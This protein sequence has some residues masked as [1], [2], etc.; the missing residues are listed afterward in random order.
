MLRHLIAGV[1]VPAFVAL[2][3]VP[4]SRP[5]ARLHAAFSGHWTGT[6]RYRDYQDSTRFVTL[7]TDL[8]AV[9]PGDSSFVRLDFTYDDGPGKVVREHDRLKLA[10][11]GR[12][13]Q[14]GSDTASAPAEYVV[15][16]SSNLERGMPIHLVLE[17]DG[18]DD[19]RPARFRETVT[20]SSNELRIRKEVRFAGATDFLFRHEYV[21]RRTATPSTGRASH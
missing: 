3:A 18:E 11:G 6:L 21:F 14:W 10:A 1:L 16:T 9:L 5:E 20:L 2:T 8:D 12:T 7:P 15:T 4:D 13:L 19:N 17:R